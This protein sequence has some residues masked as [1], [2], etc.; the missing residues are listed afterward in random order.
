L[1]FVVL[2]DGLCVRP[3]ES[4]LYGALTEALDAQR[5]AA[6]EAAGA[7]QGGASLGQVFEIVRPLARNRP[8]ERERNGKRIHSAPVR[9]TFGPEAVHRLINSDRTELLAFFEKAAEPGAL[10]HRRP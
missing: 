3:D 9:P 2:G 1:D 7:L 8:P 10:Q 5:A 4:G 6:R